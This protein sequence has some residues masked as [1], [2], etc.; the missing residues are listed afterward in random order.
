[1]VQSE[2]EG[3]MATGK[4]NRA[5]HIGIKKKILNVDFRISKESE[6]CSS[7][8]HVLYSIFSN[9]FTSEKKER[10][11]CRTYMVN[12]KGNMLIY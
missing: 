12:T 10:H 8:F 1:M 9:C 11:H 3:L 6:L 2:V 7:K 5:W 4:S